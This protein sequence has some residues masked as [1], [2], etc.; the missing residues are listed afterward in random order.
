MCDRFGA[1]HPAKNAPQIALD[2]GRFR[3]KWESHTE[4]TAITVI[5]EPSSPDAEPFSQ[6]ASA[7]LPEGW[8]D[9]SPGSVSA[10]IH[11]H[12]QVRDGTPNGSVPDH[13]RPLFHQDSL[14]GGSFFD[15]AARFWGDFR[16][17]EDGFMRFGVQCVA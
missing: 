17:H 13:L 8:L 14:I 10:A 6:A 2:L 15:D 7:L 4:F 3:F 11:V 5:A 16:I 12:C 9:E 1:P